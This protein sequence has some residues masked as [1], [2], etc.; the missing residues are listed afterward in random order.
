MADRTYT[1]YANASGVASIDIQEVPTGLIWILMQF[2]VS[3]PIAF[4]VGA[5]C[6]VKKNGLFL[7]STILGSGDTAY[8]PPFIKLHPGDNLN[9]S[10]TGLTLRDEAE[11]TLWF[12]EQEWSNNPSTNQIV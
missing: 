5:T 2:S 10:W 12:E 6:T 7:T 3:T 8:G 1:G 9:A 4:R 11:I